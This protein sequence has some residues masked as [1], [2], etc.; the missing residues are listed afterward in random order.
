MQTPWDY[1]Y[2]QRTQRMTSSTIRELLKITEKPDIISF[3]GGLPAPEVFPIEQIAEACQRVLHDN[4]AVAL[5]YGTTEGYLPLREMIVRHSERFG[6]KITTENVMITT[7]SQQALDLLGKI[8]INHGDRILV[9]ISN[10]F[11]GITSLECIRSRVH[12]SSF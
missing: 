3:G 11:G 12:S 9:E 1:R 4:G 10:L 2:A 6:I 5:Q 8:F 7:G